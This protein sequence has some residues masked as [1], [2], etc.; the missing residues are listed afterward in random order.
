M[1]ELGLDAGNAADVHCVAPRSD[2]SAGLSTTGSDI[3]APPAVVIAG[4]AGARH[5]H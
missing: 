1:D 5:T 3:S 2:G 4:R